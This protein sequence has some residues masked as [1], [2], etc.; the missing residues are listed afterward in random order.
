[1]KHSIL[2]YLFAPRFI[3]LYFIRRFFSQP[4]VSYFYIII[5]SIPLDVMYDYPSL[6]SN[7]GLAGI[8][9]ETGINVLHFIQIYWKFVYMEGS[10]NRY[11]VQQ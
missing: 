10:E 11:L 5:W 4:Q 9:N 2:I 3:Y 1:M 8:N 7:S 6:K